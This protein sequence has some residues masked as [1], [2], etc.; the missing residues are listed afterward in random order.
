MPV[1]WAG[2][3]KNGFCLTSSL[4]RLQRALADFELASEL[5]RR[6]INYRRQYL[7]GERHQSSSCN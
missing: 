6:A 2:L 7:R 3:L 1:K 5:A 4:C